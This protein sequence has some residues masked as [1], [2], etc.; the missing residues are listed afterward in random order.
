MAGLVR[1]RMAKL[2]AWRY[3][4]ATTIQ[5]VGRAYMARTRHIHTIAA[6]ME[7]LTTLEE[8]QEQ[9]RQ[10]IQLEESTAREQ[11]AKYLQLTGSKFLRSMRK[12]STAT[13]VDRRRSRRSA[14]PLV[15][16]LDA[17][18]ADAPIVR[19]LV[20]SPKLGASPRGRPSMIGSGDTIM[21]SCEL[22]RPG[23]FA[24]GTGVHTTTTPTASANNNED[25]HIRSTSSVRIVGSSGHYP[26][27]LL[28]GLVGRASVVVDGVG[29]LEHSLPHTA[30]HQRSMGADSLTASSSDTPLHIMASPIVPATNRAS[31]TPS[32][33][34]NTPSSARRLPQQQQQRPSSAAPR[35][36]TVA[37][38]VTSSVP[39]RLYSTPAW[40]ST[41]MH[42]VL[43]GTNKSTTSP[44]K[45]S[46][47]Y[48]TAPPRPQSAR[49]HHT[50][51]ATAE[52]PRAP[53]TS[54]P[55]STWTRPTQSAPPP[56]NQPERHRT[57]RRRPTSARAPL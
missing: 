25:N 47:S 31:G 56:I 57:N 7:Y 42:G 26:S 50:R 52:E 2:R 35:V 39:S 18:D 40:A 41:N 17:N 1:R 53:I 4:T 54:R 32:A 36:P 55:D 28:E 33:A 48:Q 16:L 38:K 3:R 10:T 6:V 43:L 9:R 49:H 45:P 44:T 24:L 11:L 22:I 46:S 29:S 37:K 51:I 21:S 19:V 12:K 20:P 34:N 14:S 27:P 30:P 5:S 8:A 15:S 23:S 13:T